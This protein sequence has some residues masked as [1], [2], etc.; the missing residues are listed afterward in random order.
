MSGARET[1]VFQ[2]LMKEQIV[3]VLEKQFP[4]QMSTLRNNHIVGSIILV[5]K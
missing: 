1:H 5:E 3:S 4:L 2:E